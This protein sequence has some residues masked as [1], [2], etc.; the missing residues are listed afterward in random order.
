MT[1]NDD[2]DVQQTININVSDACKEH[3]KGK[4]EKA[5][6]L[7][8]TLKKGVKEV[9]NASFLKIIK[10]FLTLIMFLFCATT[11]FFC[12]N[13]AKDQEAMNKVIDEIFLN[14]QED[15]S[16]MRIR[17]MVSPS[18]NRELGKLVYTAQASRAVIFELHNGKENA[19]NLPFRYADLSYEVINDNQK[20]VQFISNN[21]QNIP[22]THFRLPYLVAEQY[23]YFGTLEEVRKEDQRFAQ[24]MTNFGGKYCACVMLKSSGVNI[25]FLCLF[26]DEEGINSSDKKCDL[27]VMLRDSAKII[28]SLLDLNV[29]RKEY[30]KNE[31]NN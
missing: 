6:I 22:L 16:N 7:T 4:F 3:D 30:A 25:G 1:V 29:Q 19:T 21:Y 31:K 24:E 18:I 10:F 12:Y 26:F 11:A 28:S 8:S 14:K 2:K 5:N 20:E 23:I 15:E 13:V 27:D 9:T 17:D